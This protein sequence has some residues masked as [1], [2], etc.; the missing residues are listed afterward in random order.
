M[1]LFNNESIRDDFIKVSNYVGFVYK[2]TNLQTGKIYIGKKNTK[3]IQNKKLTKKELAMYDGKV[4]RKPT[5]KEVIKESD[6]LNYYGSNSQL[7]EDIKNLGVGSFKREILILC[8]NEKQLTYW[9]LVLQCQIGCLK[10]NISSYNDNILGKF[11]SK[12][13][14]YNV[15][16]GDDVLC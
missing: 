5:T 12:D 4:G 6:W 2:I 1:W 11:Y 13:D 14:L 9:E 16:M 15:V 10:E 8:T 7:K 3:S